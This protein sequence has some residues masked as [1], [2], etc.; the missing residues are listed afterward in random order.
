MNSTYQDMLIDIRHLRSCSEC[1]ERPVFF[2]EQ[3]Y[4]RHGS[5][6]HTPYHASGSRMFEPM[7]EEIDYQYHYNAF[8]ARRQAENKNSFNSRRT[9]EDYNNQ[10]NDNASP[11][12]DEDD[13]SYRWGKSK[14][15]Q[16]VEDMN[17][18]KDE[19][20]RNGSK[21]NE[22]FRQVSH[23]SACV[24]P[25]T[26]PYGYDRTKIGEDKVYGTL[27]SEGFDCMFE[28]S[29]Q[30]SCGN[31]EQI[32]KS[33]E[34][35]EE[36]TKN[37]TRKW[38]DEMHY[39]NAEHASLDKNDFVVSIKNGRKMSVEN[40]AHVDEIK[41]L[42][43]SLEDSQTKN[44]E[45]ST[46]K[47]EF[48]KSKTVNNTL[49]GDVVHLNVEI[50]DIKEREIKMKQMIKE[51]EDELQRSMQNIDLLTEINAEKESKVQSLKDG[52]EKLIN[53]LSS[54][55]EKRRDIQVHYDSLQQKYDLLKELS[56]N[57]TSK[58]DFE[59]LQ[60]SNKELQKQL[61]DLEYSYE[62]KET[63]LYQKQ[64]DLDHSRHAIVVIRKDM[65]NS[66][67][68]RSQRSKIQNEQYTK[69]VQRL[70][71][72][73][74][75][76]VIELNG[77][78]T[79]LELKT[80][81]CDFINHEI[82]KVKE[83]NQ[84]LLSKYETLKAVSENTKS[85]L[86]EKVNE[87]LCL[88]DILKKAELDIA[89]YEKNL[90]SQL[91][92]QEKFASSKIESSR[93]E[94]QKKYE[95][96]Q[97]EC[98]D[99]RELCQER[100][101]EM[102]KNEESIAKLKQEIEKLNHSLRKKDCKIE[103]SVKSL[104]NSHNEAQAYK[105]YIE[106]LQKELE[107]ANEKEAVIRKLDDQLEVKLAEIDELKTQSNDS[108]NKKDEEIFTLNEQLEDVRKISCENE[109]E[110]KTQIKNKSNEQMQIEK[111]LASSKRKVETLTN[112]L[113]DVN[114]TLIEAKDKISSLEECSEE[115][116]NYNEQLKNVQNEC[117]S[118]KDENAYLTKEIRGL[119]NSVGFDKNAEKKQKPTGLTEKKVASSADSSYISKE[120]FS[121][122]SVHS[123]DKVAQGQCEGDTITNILCD[124]EQSCTDC[125]DV[126]D[127]DAISIP[128]RNWGEEFML[129]VKSSSKEDQT[130]KTKK[131]L[132]MKT[133]SCYAESYQSVEFNRLPPSRLQP[134]EMLSSKKGLASSTSVKCVKSKPGDQD[135]I[136]DISECFESR[137]TSSKEVMRSDSSKDSLI[138]RSNPC[139]SLKDLPTLGKV[140]SSSFIDLPP[141]AESSNVSLNSLPP[142][143]KDSSFS[144][145]ESNHLH[146]N[147]SW[148]FLGGNSS[149]RNG[150]EAVKQHQEELHEENVNH[151]KKHSAHFKDGENDASSERFSDFGSDDIADLLD[152]L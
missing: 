18:I 54:V 38:A 127:S 90:K 101:D 13:N 71:S 103:A 76:N 128:K 107:T 67:C 131:C 56:N 31:M 83:D 5:K 24:L 120:T 55:K 114:K 109:N 135:D 150:G 110:L 11:T 140:S 119:K 68:S 77:I 51:K 73:I 87:N 106:K 33:F 40:N 78:K 85:E 19:L 14:L 63:E 26:R 20:R 47:E 137:C 2:T 28:K 143:L 139:S 97:T 12:R 34:E 27:K 46:L 35:R 116:K 50:N 75:E 141:L 74:D 84:K 17:L 36:F 152:E 81:D 9:E 44:I 29:V 151:E 89:T 125:S 52:N 86:N 16:F 65:A 22:V 23:M 102:D 48:V 98:S 126:G 32:Y 144:M 134:L 80:K 92:E 122:L 15:T 7:T 100:K 104:S 133:G 69:S 6:H 61:T 82:E 59:T 95:T 124:G 43:K 147:E 4:E 1:I 105:I 60:S 42:K 79:Q 25:E 70:Q 49:K 30:N 118:L 3:D 113:A 129:K 37:G 142:L 108:K 99:L 117:E 21:L 130:K 121:V 39:G 96:L 66:E 88:T 132:E 112:E 148:D 57:T 64:V 145:I 136:E 115:A 8:I 53:H 111:N 91:K 138:M 149:F 146:Q 72:T 41:S 94:M 45:L 58:I 123:D 10:H 93:D 62:L